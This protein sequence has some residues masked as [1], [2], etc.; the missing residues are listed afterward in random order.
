MS[1]WAAKN[2]TVG[3]GLKTPA[4]LY[5]HSTQNDW[6]PT[7]DMNPSS[8][9]G[10]YHVSSG[11]PT[12]AYS[13]TIGE[14]KQM[15]ISILLDPLRPV[16]YL[17]PSTF[18]VIHLFLLAQKDTLVV[19]EAMPWLSPSHSPS[20]KIGFRLALD[21]TKGLK[22]VHHSRSNSTPGSHFRLCECARE[23]ESYP[24]SL[25]KNVGHFCREHEMEFA[26]ACGSQMAIDPKVLCL[27]RGVSEF[28]SE[29]EGL[30]QSHTQPPEDI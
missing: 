9:D 19:C 12:L 29:A 17:A 25:S 8:D 24:S 28:F 22:S 11:L 20:H 26:M 16:Q 5:D 10:T 6:S 30:G 18:S 15:T 21:R 4:G 1:Q 13:I 7:I 2:I 3:R 27:I 23:R 14:W